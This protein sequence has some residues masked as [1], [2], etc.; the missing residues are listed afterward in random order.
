MLDQMREQE[1]RMDLLDNRLDRI[2]AKSV[3]VPNEYFTVAGF[4][5]IRKERID[6]SKAQIIGRKAAQLSKRLGYNIGKVSD[7]RFGSVN[8]YHVDILNEVF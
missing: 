4:A 2:E 6:V 1:E 3:T 7:P 5:T 8:T